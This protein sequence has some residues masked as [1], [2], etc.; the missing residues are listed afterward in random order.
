MNEITIGTRRS[1]LARIQTTFVRG[2]L[3]RR[4]P[5]LKMEERVILTK[6]DKILD[7]P[8][9]KIGDKGL[10]TREI[11][12]ELLEGAIDMAV[13]S[14]KDLPTELPEGLEVGAVLERVPP[15]DAIVGPAGATLESLRGGARVG[16]SSLRR[17][18]QLLHAR[19]DLNIL[20]VRGNVNTRIAKL[21]AGEY[22]ALILARAGLQRMGCEER[23]SSALGP[24][25][26]YHAVG[27]GALAIEIRV[28][29]ERMKKIV[30]ALEHEP[31]RRATDAERAFLR[32]LEGGC[33]IPVGVRT[34]IS[35]GW[36]TL[37]G[38]VAGL[39]GDPFI[40]DAE[41][42]PVEEAEAIGGRLAKRLYGCGG[43]EV[44]ECIRKP[45]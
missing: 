38:M 21:D 7:A 24:E 43:R 36:L 30:A 22:D 3:E 42:G 11:E 33:Q 29:D 14:Y 17:I 1:Q 40:E 23:M 27:Q 32:E 12:A 8:L 26:W 25:G 28:G 41:S 44:L 4:F 39:K 37:S 5:E 6:G 35:N 2:S 19:P 10:F 18:A 13:H 16:T 31:T 20:D 45:E 15:E 34:S 9:A